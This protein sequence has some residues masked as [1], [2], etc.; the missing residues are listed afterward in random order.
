MTAL[1]VEWIL[2][3]YYGPSAHRATY[4][5]LDGQDTKYTKDYLQL[6]RKEDF[7][8][9]VTNLFPVASS[10]AGSVS[11]TY[12]W[13]LGTTPG[14]LIFHSADRPHLAWETRLGA[15][16]AW[17][18]SPAPSETTAETIPGDPTHLDFQSAEKELD[19][20]KSRG[21]GQ[22]Y[23]MAI[24]LRDE[25]ATLHLRTYLKNPIKDYAWA[26]ALQV[27]QK[28]QDLIAKTSQRSALAWSTIQSGGTP[29][30]I[31][32]NSALSRLNTDE[33]MTSVIDML[34]ADTG[35]ALAS[36]LRNPGYGLFFDPSRN[37]DAWLQPEPLS[38]RIAKAAHEL[39][40]ALKARFLV[41][42]Q[43]D[44]L[45]ETLETS[46]EEVDVFRNQISDR[47]YEVPDTHAT[48]KTR[49]SAQKAFAEAVKR[50]YEFKCAITGIQT[51][52]FLV[53]AHIVPWSED[54]CIRLDPSNGIC[55]SVLVDRAFENGYLRI[56]DDL[57]ILVD[58][59][60]VG[61]DLVL[62]SQFKPYEG[63]K[64]RIPLKESPKLEYLKRRR[65]WVLLN[66]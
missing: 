41:P 64:L 62:Q 60:K 10:G 52:D 50:N 23:L 40:E 16:K 13:P 12:K 65:A 35:Y 29:P 18:M 36:Y 43:E 61:D 14:Q 51:K 17:K 4:G 45:A 3:I 11:L 5:R 63:R 27:P 31:A 58:W 66:K 21:A 25:P 49:G 9:V 34:D 37:H 26:D 6:S 32:V 56:E 2:V 8:S 55:L 57:T 42:A 30:S 7:I 39:S 1:P 24:K 53:A 15:P 28:I 33:N 54:Q 44:A 48:T 19:S 47:N 20:I 59:D 38:E 22:P 46:I